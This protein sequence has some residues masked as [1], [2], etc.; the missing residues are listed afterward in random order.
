M[1]K[2][3]ARDCPKAPD[4]K[5]LVVSGK[6]IWCEQSEVTWKTT[7]FEAL[8]KMEPATAQKRTLVPFG[9]DC[10]IFCYDRESEA[11]ECYAVLARETSPKPVTLVRANLSTGVPYPHC[12]YVFFSPE[13]AD[14]VDNWL[15]DVQRPS[16]P[17]LYSGVERAGEYQEYLRR[18]LIHIK[19]R[20]EGERQHREEGMPVPAGHIRYTDPKSVLDHLQ[21]AWSYATAEGVGWSYEEQHKIETRML[22]ELEEKGYVDLSIP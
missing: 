18:G 11:D 16:A 13:H 4:G 10:F 9:Q 12:V 5:H 14:D 7:A 21:R 20:T 3:E 22:K 8:E 6:C 15:V 19:K 1:A 17:D 2:F